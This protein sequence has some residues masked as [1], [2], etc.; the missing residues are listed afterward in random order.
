MRQI[1]LSTAIIALW[2]TV[3]DSPAVANPLVTFVGKAKERETV[4]LQKTKGQT[5]NVESK[6]FA[7]S[8]TYVR[9]LQNVYGRDVVVVVPAQLDPNEAME[10]LL[11]LRTATTLGADRV[12]LL[13]DGAAAEVRWNGRVLPASVMERF[14]A[15]AGATEIV[16]VQ[17][18]QILS[19][20]R[21]TSPLPRGKAAPGAAPTFIDINHFELT[22]RIAEA[23]GAKTLE[24]EGGTP[25]GRVFVT[26]AASAEANTT[27]FDF[28]RTA[29]QLTASG[30][31]VHGVLPYLPYARSDKIDTEGVTVGGRLVADLVEAAGTRTVT[32]MRAH[33]PQSQGFFRIPSFN[34]SGRK[35]INEYLSTEKIEIVVS[36]DAGFQKDATLYA[37]ELGVEVA[38]A[39]KQ[40][41]PISGNSTLRGFSGPPL[42]G[43]RIAII[44][45]ETASGKTLA[46]LA[47]F[48]KK[49]GALE[50]YAVVTHMAGTGAAALKSPFIDKVVTTDTLPVSPEVRANPRLKV[51]SVASEFAAHLKGIAATQSD[52]RCSWLTGV[53]SP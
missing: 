27:L 48:A 35:T 15:T 10:A 41:D 6:Q 1:A 18:E 38:V 49:S 22:S 31:E 3:A 28:L 25:L 21:G 32:F 2:F 30:R 47:E 51:L 13:I 29:S 8:N 34:L 26:A 20:P 36:P 50:V 16:V 43:K 24:S 40:R 37:D 42:Q 14:A 7:N 5:V 33:A 44:D 46:D 4:V 9:F 39:N 52:L 19:K 12:T 11:K 53:Y 17:G 23:V 45:D